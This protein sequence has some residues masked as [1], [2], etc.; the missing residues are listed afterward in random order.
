MTSAEVES[1][2]SI[3]LY[4][5]AILDTQREVGQD[6]PFVR[7]IQNYTTQTYL[8]YVEQ[9]SRQE[10]L[11]LAVILVKNAHSVAVK[12]LGVVITEDDKEAIS[13]Y[14]DFAKTN[15]PDYLN[16]LRRRECETCTPTNKTNFFRDITT[17]LE[18]AFG[19]SV[20]KN[21]QFKCS[22]TIPIGSWF[23]KTSV[24]LLSGTEGWPRY[25]Q[26]ILKKLEEPVA[27]AQLP[28][29]KV[30]SMLFWLGIHSETVWDTPFEVDTQPALK[31]VVAVCQ[32]LPLAL[33]DILDGLEPVSFDIQ[34]KVAE[35]KKQNK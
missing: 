9:L 22:V 18:A 11:D 31:S 12:S 34:A 21:E 7:S 8:N 10:R 35:W 20:K 4:C 17:E 28:S 32:H 5:W 25:Y 30:T 26:Y 3:R 14:R 1:Q 19:C 29:H 27:L 23:L 33:P 16:S 15:Y 13:R 24:E 6:Y 2:I